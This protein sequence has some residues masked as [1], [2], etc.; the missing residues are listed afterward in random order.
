MRVATPE[1]DLLQQVGLALNSTLEL[2]Q[3]LRHLAGVVLRETG[4]YRCS[5]FLLEGGVLRPA[6]AIGVAEDEGLWDRFLAM[7]PIS[8]EEIPHAGA[9]LEAG[10]A[11]QV[12]DAASSELIPAEWV[13]AFSL[14]SLV[15]VPLS[16]MGEPCGLLAVDF[17]E[18]RDASPEEVRFL[19]AVASHAGVA[20]HNARLFETTRR[21]SQLQEGLART[22]AALVASSDRSAVGR[23][24]VD[25]FVDLFEVRS[26][27][28]GLVSP[29]HSTIEV[30]ASHGV[31]IDRSVP[32][33]GI[34]AALVERLLDGWDGAS[35]LE[36]GD[37][38][39]LSSFVGADDE[40]AAS[41]LLLPLKARTHLLGGVLLGFSGR[42][43]LD[44]DEFSVAEALADIATA[45]VER[46]M[47]ADRLEQELRHTRAL[48]DLGSALAERAGSDTLISHLNRLLE[49]TDLTVT[50]LSFRDRNISQRLGGSSPEPEE[51]VA[52]RWRPGTAL[53]D[54]D[55]LSIP[56]RLGRRVVGG[57][58]VAPASAATDQQAFLEVLARGVAEVASRGALRV[59]VEEADRERAVTAE[60]G[61]IAADLHDTAGQ[62]FVAIDLMARRDAE[63][64]P[65]GSP[66]RDRFLRLAELAESGKW[67]IDR[68]VQALSL[69]PAARRGLAAS[70]RSLARSFQNDSGIDVIVD[71]EGAPARIAPRLERAVY[72]VAHEALTN[73]WKHARC[74][75]IKVEL[76][77]T[78]SEVMLK[79]I[80]DGVGRGTPARR[81]QTRTGISS[82]RRAMTEV[83]GRLR[84]SDVRPHGTCVEARVPRSGQ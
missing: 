37:D 59:A 67:E 46:G 24:L 54:D 28:L 75:T 20:V 12:F 11:V 9:L 32:I 56:M 45:A 76:T 62:T 34:P 50:G 13:E 78:S 83:S 49:G 64:L 81:A 23:S 53:L 38:P 51:R 1:G 26:C 61:R 16:V 31:E 27:V 8:I 6:A 48:H 25:A 35:P 17:Q 4:A 69:F 29:D 70:L 39:W 42:A 58:R 40:A 79:V 21:R 52:W 43:S 66:W 47:L 74:S 5:V 44:P 63:Q 60:R 30:I 15:L 14:E 57:V 41:Y 77:F 84:I 22:S 55:V 68:A 2:W 3:V 33:A 7:G 73:A 80:D 65:N 18:Q 82:M 10:R 19:E 36:V 72:R 71:V